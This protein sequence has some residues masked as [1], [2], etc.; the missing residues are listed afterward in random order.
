[1]GFA[2]SRAQ[3]RQLISH[4]HIQINGKKVNIPSFQVKENYEISIAEKSKE[5]PYIVEAKES[6]G[7]LNIP[8]WLEIDLKNLKGKVI[9]FPEREDIKS[10]INEQMIVE[11]Y[12]K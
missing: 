7:S 5:L 11:L 4:G 3:A 12:S 2:T 6:A 10:P 8:E 1:L 9:R